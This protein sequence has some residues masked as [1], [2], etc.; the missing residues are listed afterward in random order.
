MLFLTGAGILLLSFLIS[1]A[2]NPK[3]VFLQKDF[4]KQA[5]ETREL[6]GVWL[7]L[8]RNIGE[9][10]GILDNIHKAGFNVVFL[11]TLYH[12]HVIFPGSN[13]PQRPEYEGHDVLRM[14]IKE[15][16]ERG[17]AVHAWTEVFYLKV[18]T[19]QYPQ[20]PRATLFDDH[21]E[22][23]LLT[24]QGQT[25]EVSENA[26]IF[27]DPANPSLQTFLL[28]FYTDLIR[29]YDLDG[30]NLDYIR[31][32][33]GSYDTGYTAYA[34]EAF[35][36]ETGNDPK[37]MDMKQDPDDWMQWIKWREDRITD[38][39][40]RISERIKK[41]K[42]GVILS[43]SIFPEYYNNRGD[44]YTFQDWGSWLQKN[45]LDMIVPMAYASSLD[46]IK[47]EIGEV[48]QRNPQNT[49]IIPALA[50]STKTRNEYQAPDHPPIDEQIHLIRSMKI[51]GH[52]VFCYDWILQ[53]EKGL[54]SFR[55]VY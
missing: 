51:R 47:G 29:R 40:A 45:S 37:L 48:M 15:S 5:Y 8:P 52:T 50:I 28:E 27:G 38:F 14:F 55:N 22:W 41:I 36:K 43:A 39:V 42:P 12:G 4:A 30:I 6:R 20:F 32:S 46:S 54:D 25:T 49:W 44:R 16:H 33:A 1:C 53:N 34:R 11:E 17:I 2:S 26:H 9:I 35:K 10:P 21:P 3:A 24:K 31:Y 13:F 19:T 7:R 18:D 23:L